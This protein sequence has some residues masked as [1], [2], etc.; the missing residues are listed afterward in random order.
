VFLTFD[1]WGTDISITKLLRVLRKYG[2]KATFFI[3]TQYVPINPNLLRAIAAE[4][5]TIASHTCHH[6]PLSHDSNGKGFRYLEITDEEAVELGKDLEQAYNEMASIV[7]DMHHGNLPSLST[8]FRPPTLA[9]SKKGMRVVFDY[10]HSY[11]VSGTFTTQDYKATSAE[12]LMRSMAVHT[13]NGAIL[14]M[15][16]TEN[17]AYTAEALE[18]Y[19]KKMTKEHPEYKFV[20]LD[21]VLST[22]QDRLSPF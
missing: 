18:M 2:A 15:H 22:S 9:V 3:R 19:L 7:G 20:G 8:L 12:S 1:D 21:E 14:I 4:G 5:H 17:S 13:S 10:G 6:L 11:C 16:M